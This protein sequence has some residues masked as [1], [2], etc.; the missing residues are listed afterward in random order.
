[1]NEVINQIGGLYSNSIY[2]TDTDS[3]YMHKKYF[4]LLVDIGF[5]DKLFGLGK[6]D[7]GNSG[8]FMLR[9]WLPN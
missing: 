6:N 9:S 8:M 4:S 5:V 2:Y 3:L 1:M 7:Y